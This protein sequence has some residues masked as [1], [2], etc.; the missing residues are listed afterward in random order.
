MPR[1]IINPAEKI[2]KT[3]Q[4]NVEGI[5][6]VYKAVMTRLMK[7]MVK[8]KSGTNFER[9]MRRRMGITLLLTTNDKISIMYILLTARR[10]IL[11]R[12]C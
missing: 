11:W 1:L 10:C 8:A 3:H 5:E 2:C 9:A 7:W 4:A 6:R 12:R